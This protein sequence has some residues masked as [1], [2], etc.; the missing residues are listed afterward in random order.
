MRGLDTNV[1]VRYLVADDD[2]Q[3]AAVD[4][5]M[6]QCRHRQEQ[7]FVPV[8]VLCETVWVLAS[9]YEQP[10][11]AIVTALDRILS[12]DLFVV[13]QASL[14]RQCLEAYSRGK[15]DFADYVICGTTAEN[16]CRE[17]VTFD[18][19]LRGERGFTVLG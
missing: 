3:L 1:L 11:A 18:R 7:V 14:V 16:G 17:T 6:A 15:G 8:L 2:K 12:T 4:R 13:E 10:K 5:I 9:R 19:A